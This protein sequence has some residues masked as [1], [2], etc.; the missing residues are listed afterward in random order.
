M[1]GCVK[2]N[3]EDPT[4]S[5]RD[6]L[7][8]ALVATLWG[9]N[10]IAIKIGVS[11]FPPILL[12]AVRF[13]IAALLMLPWLCQV[14]KVQLKP[15]FWLMVTM[16]VGYFSILFIGMRG[17]PAGEATILIQLQVPFAA[18]LA[19]WWFKER[20]N[21]QLILGTVVAFIGVIV[22]VGVPQRMGELDSVLLL[23][24]S[25][26]LWAVSANQIRAM[27]EIHPM[28]LNAVVAAM[29]APVL[30]ALSLLIEPHGLQAFH[31]VKWQTVVAITY[32]VLVSSLFCY[33]MWF[34]LL[35]RNPVSKVVPF[36]LI[37]PPVGVL[38]A[39]LLL[40]EPLF[41][42]TFV[43]GALCLLGLALVIFRRRGN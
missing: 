25:A 14:K 28:T 26:A 21:L 42:H 39:G 33:S 15:L 37:E 41:L 31:Q 35:K 10:F 9:V 32:I 34:A 6:A 23:L 29:S 40:G 38:V 27:G 22:T 18:L 17:V 36:V 20:L 7:L 4:M 19:C 2:K 12:L 5:I 30:F 3:F 8:A 43:G 16:G 11:S 24:L 1:L 13:A